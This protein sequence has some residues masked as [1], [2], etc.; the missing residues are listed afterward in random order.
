MLRIESSYCCF[1]VNSKKM[2]KYNFKRKQDVKQTQEMYD[3]YLMNGAKDFKKK[4]NM[5]QT[6]GF[7]RKCRKLGIMT[8]T[9]R[10]GR[11]SKEISY[12]G[13][14]QSLNKWLIELNLDGKRHTII[15]KHNEDGMS[16]TDIFNGY[17]NQ[18]T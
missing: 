1:L 7:L 15:R 8:Q 2:E 16:Y 9:I 13:K 10:E 12:K 4:Y 17:L 3:F 6:S 18:N 14:V 5:S 11:T